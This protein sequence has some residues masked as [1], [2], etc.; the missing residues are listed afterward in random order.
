MCVLTRKRNCTTSSAY[1]LMCTMRLVWNGVMMMRPTLRLTTFPQFVRMTCM[2]IR[3]VGFKQQQLTG[4]YCAEAISAIAN[5][6]DATRLAV[7][8]IE[9]AVSR[10]QKQ[11]DAVTTNVTQSF[12]K[13]KVI[14]TD[15]D[16][17]FTV[18]PSREEITFQHLGYVT[19]FRTV[20]T[21][22]TNET[23]H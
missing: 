9:I 21:E 4:T 18:K 19:E 10:L 11:A 13:T 8:L 5:L 6:S 14:A 23:V 16:T 20:R 1:I 2:S 17:E 22:Q 15:T 3:R 12:V 7:L